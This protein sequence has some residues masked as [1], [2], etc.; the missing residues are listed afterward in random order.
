MTT[1]FPVT[2]NGNAPPEELHKFNIRFLT[3]AYIT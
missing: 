1:I 3:Y 2:Q